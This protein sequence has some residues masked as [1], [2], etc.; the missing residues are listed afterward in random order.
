MVY[1][2]WCGHCK[3]LKPTFDKLAADPEVL[4]KTVV[5]KINGDEARPEKFMSPI[6]EC[7]GYPSL[8]IMEKDGSW[9]EYSG[10]RTYDAI[11][12][13]VS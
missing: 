2:P 8:Y 5:A 12:K 9:S 1:A 10:A 13:E 11:K 3:A 4:A 7:R 6:S